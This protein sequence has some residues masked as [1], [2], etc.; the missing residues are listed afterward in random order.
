M[1]SKGN[2]IIGLIKRNRAYME[3]ELILSIY[4]FD[5]LGSFLLLHTIVEAAI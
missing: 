5:I 2:Q 4:D 3:K 1:A